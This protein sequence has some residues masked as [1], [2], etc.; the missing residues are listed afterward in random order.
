MKIRVLVLSLALVVISAC[1][2][3]AQVFMVKLNQWSCGATGSGNPVWELIV[4]G[5]D[6]NVLK[7]SGKADYPF[8][9][10]Q[11][12]MLENRIIQV[13]FKPISGQNDQAGGVIWRQQNRNNYYVARANALENNI[14]LYYTKDGVRHTLAYEDAPVAR[15]QWHTLSVENVGDVIKVSLDGKQYIELKDVTFQKGGSVGVWTKSD[16]VT[17][18]KDFQYTRGV[19]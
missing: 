15:N 19:K 14:S 9:T 6:E 2:K 10:H 16:S 3:E 1:S 17:L 11:N 5:T 13:Q 8:C 18:F 12:V 7:Q 4:D